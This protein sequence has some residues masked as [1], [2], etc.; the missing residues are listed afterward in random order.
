MTVH[1]ILEVASKRSFAS[2]V[3]WP[4]WSRGANTA[5]DAL[6][7]LLGYAPRYARVARRA[8]LTFRPPATV[9]GFDVVE[10]LTG[11]ASTEFGV[12]RAIATV[13]DDPVSAADLKRLLALLR[14]SW[15]TFDAAARAAEIGRAHV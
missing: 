14:A 15:A 4:G 12:P 7:N 6:E 8:K 10:R 5:E 11:D 2:A 1:V 9:A 13:E 3:D